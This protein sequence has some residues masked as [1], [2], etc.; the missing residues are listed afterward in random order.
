MEVVV[1]PS[2]EAAVTLTAR[3]VEAEIR[4]RPTAVLGLATGRTMEDVYAALVASGASFAGVTTFNLDE[5]VGL[6][7]DDPNAYAAYMAHHL[8]ARTDIDPDNT[9]L[10]DGMADDIARAAED[11][12]A[13]ITA[14]GG[15]DL[16][17][18]G[19]GETGHIGFNEPL[20]SLRS[21]TRDKIL[22]PTTRAQ[23]AAMFG[24]DPE[25]VPARALTMGVGTIL[26]SR[27]LL[28][29]ACGQAKAE[30]VARAIEGPVTAAISASAI[31][32]HNACQVVLDA[33]AASALQGRDYYD[34]IVCN[35]PKWD[36]H[37]D[38]LEIAST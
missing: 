26:E 36:P 29:L 16:Q 20:S 31:Q 38:L 33:E 35:E 14:A 17:L 27:R 12:E 10:P 13:R 19:I 1:C 15:I 9:H 6:P 34:F 37:R 3:L 2:S 7:P 25:R 30:V 18:L 32:F 4:A 23:N 21:R 22:T 11:Y 28:L 24:G 8:F 5:Y